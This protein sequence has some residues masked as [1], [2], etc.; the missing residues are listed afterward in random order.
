MWQFWRLE[1]DRK[2]LLG[3]RVWG[4]YLVSAWA[5]EAFS[6]PFDFVTQSQAPSDCAQGD[7]G[8]KVSLRMETAA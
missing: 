5:E 6:G 7:K 4:E 2:A 8:G 3:E 1:R